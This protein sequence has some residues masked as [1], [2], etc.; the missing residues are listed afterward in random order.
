[1]IN[2]DS[3]ADGAKSIDH[4]FREVL[5]SEVCR[6]GVSVLLIVKSVKI[7]RWLVSAQLNPAPKLEVGK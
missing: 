4:P 3:S 7:D 6:S 2:L 5:V 1:V